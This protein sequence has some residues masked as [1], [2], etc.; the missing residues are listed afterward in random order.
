MFAFLASLGAA[1]RLT[2]L[3]PL[4]LQPGSCDSLRVAHRKASR[5]MRFPAAVSGSVQAAAICVEP[6]SRRK[7]SPTDDFPAAIAH[8]VR[9]LV[10]PCRVLRD[11]EL[12]FSPNYW[13]VFDARA[14]ARLRSRAQP[15]SDVCSAST[16][17][18]WMD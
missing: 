18:T 12:N 8:A 2:L 7:Q 16:T 11:N 5:M 4:P 15:C 3:V 14:R 9:P 13:F 17:P 6:Q 1:T 10:Q